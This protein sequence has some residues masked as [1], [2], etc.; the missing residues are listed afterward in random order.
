MLFRSCLSIHG[1][2]C[3]VCGLN[4]KSVYGEVI[5]SIIEVHHIEPLSE[6]AEARAYNPRTDLIP[7]CPNCHRAIHKR[8][9]AYKPEELK[10]MLNR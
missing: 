2:I 1:E 3:S 6:V 8:R 7:L 10:G 4:P 9:P 5:N